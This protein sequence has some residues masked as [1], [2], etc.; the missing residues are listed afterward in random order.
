[1]SMITKVYYQFDWKCFDTFGEW[2]DSEISE[3]LSDRF[4]SLVERLE[5]LTGNPIEGQLKQAGPGAEGEF[6]IHWD[7]TKL[8]D[9]Y[10]R[11]LIEEASDDD[12]K[13][14]LSYTR[15]A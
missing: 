12:L 15:E 10:I 13:I 14:T 2:V 1:M 5:E 9:G 8:T 6:F 4:C 11:R 7:D 3:M